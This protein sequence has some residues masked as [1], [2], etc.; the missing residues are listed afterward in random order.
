M[1]AE[2]LELAAGTMDQLESS[3][4]LSDARDIASHVLEVDSSAREI[5]QRLVRIYWRLG[6]RS[7]ASAQY[8]HLASLDRAD[9]LEPPSLRDVTGR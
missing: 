6:A 9:G 8:D 7:A 5:E 1:H 3:G 2:F 4:D